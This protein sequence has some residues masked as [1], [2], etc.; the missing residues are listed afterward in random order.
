MDY[1]K[2]EEI[3]QEIRKKMRWTGL[4]EGSDGPVKFNCV[5]YKSEPGQFVL[6]NV[7][8]HE[9]FTRLMK[10]GREKQFDYWV[11]HEQ[12]VA[13]GSQFACTIRP[14]RDEELGFHRETGAEKEQRQMAQ[15]EDQGGKSN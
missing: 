5:S 11:F 9:R 4:L 13:I 3:P 2:Y 8:M 6:H 15:A 12:F 14:I 1:E 10:D 7:I